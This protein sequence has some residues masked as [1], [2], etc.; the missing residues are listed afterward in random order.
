MFWRT[1]GLV[2]SSPV[3]VRHA[4]TRPTPNN[5]SW[6]AAF[7]LPP[8]TDVFFFARGGLVSQLV[9]DRESFTLE[10]LL[11]EDDV[12][13]ECKSLNNRLINL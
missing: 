1:A 13:Q 12:I 4:L 3:E 6:C 10:E 8:L 5:S 9:L 7:R 2:Q 11:E